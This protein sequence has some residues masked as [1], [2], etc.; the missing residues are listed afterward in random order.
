MTEFQQE[1][2]AM[3]T[4]RVRR[5]FA[6]LFFGIIAPLVVAQSNHRPKVVLI[7]LD[8]FAADSLHD[9]NLPIPTLRALEKSGAFAVSM[10]P[11][12]PTVTWPNHTSIITGVD[13]SRHHVLVN[14]LIERQR[15]EARPGFDADAAKTRLVAVPTLYDA[16]HAAGLVTAEI[17]WVAILHAPSIDWSFGERPDP[18]GPI[19]QDLIHQGVATLAQ[20][21]NFGRPS[22]AWRDRMYTA[23][24]VDILHTRHPDLLMLHLLALDGIEHET[25]YGNS[26]GRNTIA[27]LDDRVKEVMDAVRDAGELDN[28][29]FIIV[30]DHG[31]SSV[32]HR[33]HADVLLQQA[34]LQQPGLANYT[35]CMNDGGFAMIYQ[36]NASPASIDAL[37]AIFIAK[38]GVRAALSPEEAA[39][40]GWPTPATTDQAPDLLLYADVGYAFTA[41]EAATFVTDAPETGTHGY[42]NTD[43]LM[44]A[45]FIASGAAVKPV[46]QVLSFRNLDVAPTIARIL[47]LSLPNVQGKP[48][49][50][51]LQEQ[52]ER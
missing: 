15:T 33:L 12:N 32:H 38:P 8:A 17:D 16:A 14:G 44:Q 23:A 1:R 5:F 30:S 21:E 28:T 31:Q 34:G 47:H 19:A 35:S 48:H 27:F 20:L 7:S 37:K 13:A 49:D 26:A 3:S 10:Q 22:Q 2:I 4:C 29:T 39:R 36:R 52:S 42:P 43:P 11:I 25:G 41:G 50:E 45:I 40:D 9:P 24:A 51:I 6:V 18:A 46:G